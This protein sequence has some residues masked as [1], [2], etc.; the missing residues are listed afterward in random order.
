[1]ALDIH[2]ISFPDGLANTQRQD[3][4]LMGYLPAQAYPAGSAAGAAVTLAV[5]VKSLPAK[6]A[7]QVS[8]DQ[9][10]TWFVTKTATGFTVTLLP[11][12]AANTL[13]S[14]ALDILIV[15]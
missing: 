13:A 4:V 8:P 9:D 11:R 3:R 5:A 6:F 15:A 12:L 14:G 2:T 10:C 7:V 1:M